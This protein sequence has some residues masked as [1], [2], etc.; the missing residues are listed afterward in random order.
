MTFINMDS[1]S[2]IQTRN[3]DPEKDETTPWTVRPTEEEANGIPNKKSDPLPLILGIS[4][5][6]GV[7]LLFSIAFVILMIRRRKTA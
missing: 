1:F 6:L 3:Y 4:I 7:A 5:P 2:T